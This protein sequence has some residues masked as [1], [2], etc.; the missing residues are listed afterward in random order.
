MRPHSG[1]A[2]RA[3]QRLSP[4]HGGHRPVARRECPDRALCGGLPDR[5]LPKVSGHF[6]TGPPRFS[7]G[8][9]QREPTHSASTVGPKT[10]CHWGAGSR[11]R[12]SPAP[13]LICLTIRT[14]PS[15]SL[16]GAP[17]GYGSEIRSSLCC[18]YPTFLP[19]AAHGPRTDVSRVVPLKEYSADWSVRVSLKDP[20]PRGRPRRDEVSRW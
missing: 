14:R 5:A 17:R 12:A 7:T 18:R 2:R 10:H 15:D 8:A 4:Q 16:P 6:A 9:R 19:L 11:G 3:A 13:S 1:R 20:R